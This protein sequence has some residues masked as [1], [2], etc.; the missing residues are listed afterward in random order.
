MA[1]QEAAVVVTEIENSL[2]AHIPGVRATAELSKLTQYEV[3]TL[4]GLEQGDWYWFNRLINQSGIPH[5][6][7]LLLDAV[8]E[9]C[10]ERNYSILNQVNAYGDV[11]QHDLEDWY[12]RKGFTPVDSNKYG[13][14]LLKWVPSG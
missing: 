12:I 10:R 1:S 14:A 7:T 2:S 11:S 4:Y 9:Y 13:N 3:V 6:G 5:V 8:L